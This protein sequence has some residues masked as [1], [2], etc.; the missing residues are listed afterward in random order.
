LAASLHE[1]TRM[2]TIDLVEFY[3]GLPGNPVIEDKQ[4]F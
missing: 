2:K 1:D 4:I 3:Q